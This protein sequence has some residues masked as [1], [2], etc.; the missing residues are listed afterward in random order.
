MDDVNRIAESD[1][2]NNVMRKKITIRTRTAP[3][4][5]DLNGDGSIDWVDVAIVAEMAQG[6]ITPTADADL[7]GDGT[8]PCSLTS[9]SAGHPLCNVCTRKGISPLPALFYPVAGLK[10]GFSRS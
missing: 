7:N 5:G 3:V 1:E 8:V 10:A 4:K 9:S 6:K 2:T